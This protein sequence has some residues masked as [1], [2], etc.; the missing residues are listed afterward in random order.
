MWFTCSLLYANVN[1]SLR[2]NPQRATLPVYYVLC[3]KLHAVAFVLSATLLVDGRV[4]KDFD[5]RR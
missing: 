3:C 2:Q 5:E 1:K 4:L